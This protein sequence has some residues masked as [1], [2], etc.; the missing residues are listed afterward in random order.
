[1][2][3]RILVFLL[4]AAVLPA[5]SSRFC[6]AYRSPHFEIFYQS[7]STANARVTL[8]WLEQLRSFFAAQI[9][10][11]PKLDERVRVIV[12]RSPKDYSAYQLSSAADAYFAGTG[13]QTYVVTSEI[14]EKHLDVLAHEY[15]H[16]VLH[17]ANIK[18]PPWLN[19]GLAEVF[20]TLWFHP[21]GTDLG[22]PIEAHVR[23]LRTDQWMTVEQLLSIPQ[24]RFENDRALAVRFYAHAWA[25]TEMLLFSPQYAAGF[26]E[27]TAALASGTPEAKAFVDIY[28]KD[29]RSL[30]TDLHARSEHDA[31]SL[32]H[33]P[34]PPL[35]AVSIATEDLSATDSRVLLAGLLV[36]AGQYARAAAEYRELAALQ[37]GNAS[38]AAALGNIALHQH[39]LE[40]ARR[41]WKRALD[42][43]I[44]D[45]VLCYQYAILADQMNLSA[46][47]VR[48]ALHRAVL[49]NPA[50]YDARWRL[51]ILEEDAGNFQESAAQLKAMNVISPSRA[52]AYWSTLSYV[53]EEVEE[54]EAAAKAANTAE[55]FAATPDE[56]SRARELAYIAQTEVRMRLSI[57]ANGHREMVATRVPRGTVDWNPFVQPAD[58]MR[59]VRGMLSDVICANGRL[60]GIVI[61]GSTDVTPLA[62]SDPQLVLILNGPSQFACGAQANAP[63][64]VADYAFA[65]HAETV[66]IAR[67][68]RFE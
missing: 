26:R 20:S 61:R 36:A 41:E 6:K 35:P 63:A 32:L 4:A 48:S 55:R 64:V 56:R 60:T 18:L 21:L 50:F 25:L 58:K 7:G 42:D 23:S 51:A 2:L 54:H 13:D 47:E 11:D 53:E 29:F 24:D 9:G 28:R 16:L 33:L 39:D 44:A 8:D 27:F 31:Y 59:R 45:P 40:T 67:A 49:L 46:E 19:E 65:P 30:D 12:F 3:P 34:P 43:G 17:S 22:G 38:F 14:R 1:M 66:G 62:V 52:F 5:A 10:F 37:P 15:A 68:I 57:D